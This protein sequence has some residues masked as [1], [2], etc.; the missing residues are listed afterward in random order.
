MF[1]ISKAHICIASLCA[2]LGLGCG[3]TEKSQPSK[4]ESSS[5]TA[6]TTKSD[7]AKRA[8]V[9]AKAKVQTKPEV[10]EKAPDFTLT[11]HD[12]KEHALATLLA[13][14]PAVLVFYRG[15]W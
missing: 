2:V 13:K 4:Q 12:G 10:L 7:N 1:H 14:G 11:G 3:S 6:E 5:T 9:K 8:E 15:H